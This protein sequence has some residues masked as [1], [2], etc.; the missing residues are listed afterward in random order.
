[1]TTVLRVFPATLPRLRPSNASQGCK[2]PESNNDSE[3]PLSFTLGDRGK[4]L[5]LA[6]VFM[7]WLLR[8]GSV[9]T[10]GKGRIIGKGKARIWVTLSLTRETRRRRCEGVGVVKRSH[11]RRRRRDPSGHPNHSGVL[12]SCLSRSCFICNALPITVMFIEI[13][14]LAVKIK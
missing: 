8:R 1:M 5:P 9:R 7:P 4:L 2:I 13:R 10:E 6:G 14:Q 3:H 11:P 12:L